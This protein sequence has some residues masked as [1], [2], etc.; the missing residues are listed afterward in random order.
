MVVLFLNNGK[1]MRKKKAVGRRRR[2][3]LDRNK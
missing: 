1:T 2:N 3:D